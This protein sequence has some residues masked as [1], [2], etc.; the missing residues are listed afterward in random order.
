MPLLSRAI[1]RD[2]AT[3][4]LRPWLFDRYCSGHDSWCLRSESPYLS[5]VRGS[6]V[7]RGDVHE[8]STCVSRA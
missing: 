8:V 7:G 4:A 6:S 3:A 2:N 1:M 5:F